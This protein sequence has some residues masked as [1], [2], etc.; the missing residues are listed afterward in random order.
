MER[1]VKM[2]AAIGLI[3]AAAAFAL[4]NWTYLGLGSPQATGICGEGTEAI[5]NST[6]FCALDITS[7]LEFAGNGYSRLSGRINYMGV[8]FSTLCQDNVT[9]GNVG[10]PASANGTC[11]ATTIAVF[12][13]N[14][15]FSD[16]TNESIGTFLGD[17]IPPPVLSQHSSPTAG[18]EIQ[19][20]YDSMEFLLLV[21][22]P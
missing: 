16:G 5:V 1:K 8:Q 14:L 21:Q 10:C 17:S 13:F 9:C 19:G 7:E 4:V 22:E 12:K 2:A 20:P 6:K 3:L 11:T 18:F 15:V